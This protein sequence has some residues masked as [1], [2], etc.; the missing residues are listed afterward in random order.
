MVI[1][2][3]FVYQSHLAKNNE[4]LTAFKNNNLVGIILCLFLFLEIHLI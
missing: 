3:F 1:S 2:L 4:Y